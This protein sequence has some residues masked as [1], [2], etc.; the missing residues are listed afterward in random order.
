MTRARD[1]VL[2]GGSGL[3]CAAVALRGG[4]YWN[5]VLVL[6][7]VYA[8]VATAWNLAAGLSG[9]SSFG[10]GLFFGAGAYTATM[11]YGSAGVSPWLGLLVGAAVGGALGAGAAWLGTRYQIGGL[12]FAVLTL[13]LAEIA[14]LFVG[15]FEPLGASRGLTIAPAANGPAN[16][17]FASTA[18]FVA[19]A[20]AFFAAC[21]LATIAIAHGATGLRYRSVRENPA[22]AAAMG[23]EP[24]RV[25]VSALAISGALTAIGG[26]VYAQYLLFVNPSIFGPGVTINVILF[27]LIGGIGTVWGPALGTLVVYPIGAWLRGTFG[28]SL[29]GVDSLVYGVLVV[30]CILGFPRGIV[31]L[32]RALRR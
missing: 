6:L 22:A 12:S 31:G 19:T 32:F 23:I 4:A 11:L 7:L 1:L 15:S 3:V 30:A 21:M 8:G 17:Q 26:V 16:L 10:H 20:F 27:T 24:L 25:R 14:Q 29:P 28:G 9:T 13:A 2:L 5:D 18:A